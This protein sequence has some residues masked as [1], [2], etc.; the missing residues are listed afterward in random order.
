MP[1]RSFFLKETPVAVRTSKA[2]ATAKLQTAALCALSFV[3]KKDA[4]RSLL[5]GGEAYQVDGVFAGKVDGRDVSIDVG[6]LL[7]VGHDSTRAKSHNPDL[8]NLIAL[9]LAKVPKTRRA[10]ILDLLPKEFS[11]H[12]TI[13]AAEPELTAAADTLLKSLRSRSSANVTGS[14]SFERSI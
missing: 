12:K 11:E 14:V 10:D 2:D 13:P 4:N 3:A 5:E 6:G 9:I 1:S 7:Q 8:P